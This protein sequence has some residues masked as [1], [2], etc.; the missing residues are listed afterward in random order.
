MGACSDAKECENR[1][2]TFSWYDKMFFF[3]D[4]TV[5]IMY[6]CMNN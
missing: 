2:K 4:T 6:V 1:F 3:A 5:Q